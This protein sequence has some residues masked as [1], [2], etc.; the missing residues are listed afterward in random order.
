MDIDF[1]FVVEVAGWIVMGGTMLAYVFLVLN[2][3]IG[4]RK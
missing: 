4:R 1:R 3:F 2:E